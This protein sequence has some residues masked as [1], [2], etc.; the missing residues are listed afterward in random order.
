[1]T[2]C[3][4]SN[5]DRSCSDLGLKAVRGTKRCEDCVIGP[6][7]RRIGFMR[8]LDARV[9]NARIRRDD[10]VSTHAG[11]Q[12]RR[13]VAIKSCAKPLLPRVGTDVVNHKGCLLYT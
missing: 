11:N 5:A 12:G 13:W 4:L 9:S 1:M 2:A 3:T 10:V 6:T 7:I 8:C